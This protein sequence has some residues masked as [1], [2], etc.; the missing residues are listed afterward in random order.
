LANKNL[1]FSI[2]FKGGR[3]TVED[4]HQLEV[5]LKDITAQMKAAEKAGDAANF[6][7]LSAKFNPF[8]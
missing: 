8:H 3:E 1:I 2:G 7:K 5:A 4:L 6:K